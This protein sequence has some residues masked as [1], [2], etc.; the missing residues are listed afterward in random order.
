MQELKILP[1]LG[2]GPI[3]LNMDRAEVRKV[4]VA[5]GCRR[6]F[7]KDHMD[8]FYDNALQVEYDEEEKVMFIGVSSSCLY[9]TTYNGVNVFDT[10]AK[11]LFQLIAQQDGSEEHIYDRNG[12]LFPK[13]IVALWN[14]D[15][16]YD[17]IQSETRKVWGQIGLG[18]QRYFEEVQT[19][20]KQNA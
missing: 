5:L 20:S 12:H 17:E 2:I 16:Q 14:A 7:T 1:H 11:L 15:E 18:N 8:Y 3:S 6:S 9:K 4:M 10:P 13:Q 19:L